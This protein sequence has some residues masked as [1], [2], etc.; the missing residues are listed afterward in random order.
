MQ[1]PTAASH[2]DSESAT[3]IHQPSVL[4]PLDPD[5]PALAFSRRG[6]LKW[7]DYLGCYLPSY[8][9]LHDVGTLTLE[10]PLSE[11][12]STYELSSPMKRHDGKPI[13][14]LHPTLMTIF[15]PASKR[16]TEPLWRQAL[17]MGNLMGREPRLQWITLAQIQGY[18]RFASITS[19]KRWFL[20]P[21][22][23]LA[24]GSTKLPTRGGAPICLTKHHRQEDE[25]KRRRYK[26][27]IFSHGL[28]GNRTCYSQLCGRLAAQGYVVAAV[29]HRDGTSS[30]SLATARTGG[31]TVGKEVEYVD[32]VDV[33]ADTRPDNYLIA[34]AFQLEL[35]TIE[36][37]AAAKSLA[38]LANANPGWKAIRDANLRVRG[39]PGWAGDDGANW[40]DQQW[41]DFAGAVD[42]SDDVTIAG[43][44]FGAANVITAARHPDRPQ[45]WKRFILYDPWLETLEHCSEKFL[46]SLTKTS[47]GP[48]IPSDFPC[49]IINA[50]GF[51][52][53]KEHFK[54]LQDYFII[55]RKDNS[56]QNC[57]LVVL[58]GAIHSSFSDLPVLVE[59]LWKK[60]KNLQLD[61]QK[62][63]KIVTDLTIEFIECRKSQNPTAC[64]EDVGHDELEAE[65]FGG[66]KNRL[67]S[68]LDLYKPDPNYVHGTNHLHESSLESF[69]P[70][71]LLVHYKRLF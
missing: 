35:R 57:L 46:G 7:T 11:P 55:D 23:L 56:N 2:S 39:A 40:S 62:A 60:T 20:I 26:L 51:T 53:W 6:P 31:K 3:T 10:L 4:P 42:W 64:N 50:P 1:R 27:V 52:V 45:G 28:T 15:Y 36:L 25:E 8:D 24:M 41:D 17:S 67:E 49:L 61:S 70:G 43:H 32:M 47:K 16:P 44:S 65:K 5:T 37:L 63:I 66:G 22:L 21:P 29:E 9:G 30:H 68:F 58:G 38:S 13:L 59:W 19:W 71:K 18:L 48:I 69:Q 33:S 12:Y 34:R 14:E 54:K